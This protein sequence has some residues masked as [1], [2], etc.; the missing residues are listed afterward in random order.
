[1]EGAMNDVKPVHYTLHLEPD[2]TAW[3]FSGRIEI[4]LEAS[5]PVNRITLNTKELT[6]LSCSVQA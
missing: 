3:T 1:L 5:R 4:S 2:L 6:L